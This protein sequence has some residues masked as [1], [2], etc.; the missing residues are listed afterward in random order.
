MALLKI[1]AH[2]GIRA[3]IPITPSCVSRINLRLTGNK[4]HA[5][6]PSKT[7]SGATKHTY[8]R[9]VV[10]Y[11][12]IRDSVSHPNDAC[13]CIEYAL[14][15]GVEDITPLTLFSIHKGWISS[16]SA[17]PMDARIKICSDH[18]YDE[19]RMSI[20]RRLAKSLRKDREQW[21]IAKAQEMEKAAAIGNS[22]VLF[23]PIRNTGPRKPKASEVICEKDG[24]L[25][26][27]QHRLLHRWS[28]HFQEQFSWPESTTPFSSVNPNPE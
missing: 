3:E 12:S 1:A 5:K 13:K 25:I 9:G 26:H 17:A 7:I 22:R 21:W 10:T 6:V 24:N 23:Q 4:F 14:E 28:E 2:F 18:R 15:M 27:S 8:Q 16:P 19:Q 20:K 11:L